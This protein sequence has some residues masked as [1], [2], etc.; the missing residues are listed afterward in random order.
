MDYEYIRQSYGAMFFPG[1]IVEHTE[2][3]ERGE[4]VKPKPGHL[5]YVRV[6]FGTKGPGLCH[7]GALKI[8]ARGGQWAKAQSAPDPSAGEK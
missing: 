1:D 7:P 4:V 5:H 2:T 3:H 8:I 6:H